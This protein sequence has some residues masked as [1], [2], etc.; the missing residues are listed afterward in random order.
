MVV[1]VVFFIL[2]GDGNLV[3]ISFTSLC[4]CQLKNDYDGGVNDDDMMM[5]SIEVSNVKMSVV[6]AYGDNPMCSNCSMGCNVLGCC[7]CV[8]ATNLS[9]IQKDSV[10]AHSAHLKKKNSR[11][12]KQQGAHWWG[13]FFLNNFLKKYESLH[14]NKF[15]WHVS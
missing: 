13:F 10:A 7:Q 1:L 6:I 5:M 9:S 11:K 8:D 2:D 14:V 4:C 12:N 3:F 15:S